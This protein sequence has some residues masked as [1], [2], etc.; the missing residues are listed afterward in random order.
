MKFRKT[1]LRRRPGSRSRSVLSDSNVQNDYFSFHSGR[2]S[3]EARR[4]RK[5]TIN[6]GP[7]KLASFIRRLP[8]RLILIILLLAFMYCG[9]ITNSPII[10]DKTVLGS[11]NLLRD[12]ADYIAAAKKYINSSL[13]NNNKITFDINGFANSMK[14]QFPELDR[15]DVSFSLLSSRP[16]IDLSAHRITLALVSQ[17]GVY[18]LNNNGIAIAKGEDIPGYEKLKIPKVNDESSL[19]ITLGKGVLTSQEISYITVLATQID[20][21][22]PMIDT[23]SL[24]PVVNQLNL[25]LKQSSFIVKFDMQNDPRTAAGA[26]LALKQRLDADHITPSLYMDMRLEGRAFY[27]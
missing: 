1:N 23:I 15:A 8:G 24:P 19:P 10:V 13:L 3:S 17:Q 22:K 27:K 21:T 6:R 11:I 20:H 16:T 4:S 26:F 18:L 25:K 2:L 12:N 7:K 9:R 14:E 5:Q